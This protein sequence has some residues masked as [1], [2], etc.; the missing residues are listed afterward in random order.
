MLQSAEAYKTARGSEVLGI[1]A[2][3]TFSWQA[4]LEWQATAV[5][6]TGTS[7]G[8]E[9][10]EQNGIDVYHE[11]A[12]FIS[13]KR[14]EA[15]GQIYQA[16]RF[17][18]ATGSKTFIPPIPG[19]EGSGYIT[20]TE[21]LKLQR[22]PGS[23]IIIG[24]G[25][26]GCEFAELFS[27]F[28]SKVYIVETLPKLLCRED[29]EV[30]QLVKAVF[31]AKGIRVAV[32]AKVEAIRQH[33]DHKIVHIEKNGRD[34][35]LSAEQVLVATGKTA[36]TDLGL[37]KAKVKFDHKSIHANSFLQTSNPRIYT[38]GDATG[39]YLF[40]HTAEYQSQVAVYNCFH[41]RSR[42]RANYRAVPRCTFIS[43]EVASVGAC[44]EELKSK[45][46]PYKT[47]AVPL[48]L[49]GRSNTS[50]ED[51]GFAKIIADKNN[52]ILGGSVVGPRAGEVINELALAIHLGAK[53]SDVA[54][55]IHAF[56]TFSEVLMYA[57]RAVK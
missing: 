51:T 14:I 21:A 11:E 3:P 43:P 18:I 4:I 50:G 36:V 34:H 54:S 30:S 45:G 6:N 19:L 40:T 57:A 56:P 47:G 46:I 16:K 33:G 37:D 41:R 26:I 53:V 42:H 44:E 9:I 25:A 29:D 38:A 32:G 5:A 12:R 8:K 13:P 39:P 23:I 48:S 7:Q 55:S 1:K 24:G 31:E 20:S 35:R 49:I 15:G 22:V 28:G 27:T 10:F 52:R 2:D 17:L